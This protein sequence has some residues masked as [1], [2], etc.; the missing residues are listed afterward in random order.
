MLCA[1]VVLTMRAGSIVV[2]CTVVISRICIVD[3]SI[4]IIAI[5]SVIVITVFHHRVNHHRHLRIRLYD[6]RAPVRCAIAV[7]VC[8]V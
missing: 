2:V 8:G 3:L 6:I 1:G 4:K 5:L 7:L